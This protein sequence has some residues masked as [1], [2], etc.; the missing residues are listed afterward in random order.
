VMDATRVMTAGSVDLGEKPAVLSAIAK[1]HMTERAR[2]SV[3]DAMDIVGGKG[4]CLGPN[5]WVGRGYQMTPIAITVEGANILTR[6]LITF[7]QGALRAHPYLYKEI[8]AAQNPDRRAGILAFDRAFA[9]HTAFML[10]NIVGSFLHALTFGA[11]A[12]APADKG[13]MARW[14]RQLARYAQ[15]FALVADW[16]VAFLGGQLKARQALSGRMADILSELYILSAA[17]KRYEDEGRL[18]EDASVV[19]AIARDCIFQIETSF[20]AVFAN[21]PNRALAGL[22]RFL[23]FPLGR[24]V[25]P[26]AD[27]VNFALA[28]AAEKPGAFRDRMTKGTYVSFDPADP[29]GVLEDALVKVVAAEEIERKF[30]RALKQG[31]VERR[32]DRDAIEDAVTAGVITSA[33]AAV[34]RTADEATDRAIRVDDFAPDELMRILSQREPQAAE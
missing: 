5:N 3:N 31:I 8:E 19:E 15:S 28:A 33:E 4:I 30:I 9:G 10:R 16:T 24:H 1:Y 11:F 34:L 23:V 27:R 18:V 32:L 20:A 29:T 25:R 2:Q 14:Y 26:A 21:F 13:E 17:L 12:T 6:T 7:A 22:M